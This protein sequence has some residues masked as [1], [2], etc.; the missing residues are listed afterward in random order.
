[1]TNFIRTTIASLLLIAGSQSVLGQTFSSMDE[2]QRQTELTKI[3]LTIY[4]NPK[5]SKYYS[6][7]GYCGRSEISTYNIKGEGD[8]KARKEYLGTQQYV[9]NL[10]CKKGADWGELPIAK[11]YVSDKAGKAWMIR[12]GNDNM[13]FPYWNFPEIFK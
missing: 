3:A 1:M 10:Y 5:F 6:K 11:V 9:V 8:D 7:Y 4:K 12:F 13:M 2:T